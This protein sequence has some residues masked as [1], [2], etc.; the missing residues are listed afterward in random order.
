LVSQYVTLAESI[1]TGN[2]YAENEERPIT[3]SD[4]CEQCGTSE[5]QWYCTKDRCEILGGY[6]G[7]CQYIPF[8]EGGTLDGLCLPDNPDDTSPPSVESVSA[9]FYNLDNET[10]VGPV[11]EES[12]N[13]LDVNE[14]IPWS[15]TYANVNITTSEEATCSYSLERDVSYS[16]GTRFTADDTYFSH[17]VKVWFDEGDRLRGEVYVYIKCKDYIGNEMDPY[18]NDNFVSFE[19]ESR[20][21][22]EPPVID[23]IAPLNPS[24]PEGTDEVELNLFAYDPG[25]VGDCRYS[26]E[27]E[28]SYIDMTGFGQGTPVQCTQVDDTCKGFSTVFDLTER[29]WGIELNE[30]EGVVLYPL[31]I[32]CEDLGGNVMYD[33]FE[34]ALQVWPGF[35]FTIVSPTE[36]QQFYDDDVQI[37]VLTGRDTTCTYTLVG[38]GLNIQG[39]FSDGA[40]G[41]EHISIEFDLPGSPG[42]ENYDLE[43]TCTDYAGNEVME[44]VDFYLFSDVNAPRL[45][46]LYTSSNRLNIVLDEEASCVYRTEELDERPMIGS[47]FTHSADLDIDSSRYEIT[48]IDTWDN[49][50]NYVIYP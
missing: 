2:C 14:L 8:E 49:E 28:V 50:A 18:N 25:G 27:S 38:G 23:Y 20:P 42:G 13:S 1:Q 21:D 40:L 22:R 7:W 29:G 30:S 36:G 19:F 10:L 17:G 24:I 33:P 32:L 4:S 44:E 26:K 12:G 11:S 46:R 45:L 39:N 37:S 15:S 3:N 16:G 47:G 31:Y 5:G 48:C 6:A 41:T 34:W 43:V 9:Q 35:E